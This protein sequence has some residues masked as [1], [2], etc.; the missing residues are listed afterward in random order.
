MRK[1][2]ASCKFGAVPVIV[3]GADTSAG[4][5][6]LEG[7][8]EPK[9]LRAFVSDERIGA[10]LKK[11]GFKVALG[12]VSDESHIE[13][14]SARCFSAILI[15]EAAMDD[16]ERTFAKTVDEVLSCWAR[17]VVSSEVSR[18]IWVSHADHPQVPNREVARVDP[19]DPDLVEKVVALD[20]AQ[21]I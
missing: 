9:Q 10:R 6:I 18:V 20:E 14:A 7:L 8:A 12:D 16:R 11:S 13:T 2:S 4:Q 15:T 19:D 3:V 17:A 21:T 1:L 5:A